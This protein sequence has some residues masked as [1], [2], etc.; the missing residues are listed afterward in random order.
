[1]LNFQLFGLGGSSFLCERISPQGAAAAF[2]VAL[3]IAQFAPSLQ[4]F[5]VIVYVFCFVLKYYYVIKSEPW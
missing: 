2:F 1:V 5:F 3:E 4:L